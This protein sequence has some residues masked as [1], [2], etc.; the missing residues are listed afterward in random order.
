MLDCMETDKISN[1]ILPKER[2]ERFRVIRKRRV[3]NNSHKEAHL[4]YMARREEYTAGR[5]SSTSILYDYLDEQGL[6][7]VLTPN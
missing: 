1:L 5:L 7:N 3:S 4:S 6:Q 2:L